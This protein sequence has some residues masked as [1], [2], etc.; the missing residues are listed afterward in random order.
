MEKK[1]PDLQIDLPHIEELYSYDVDYNATYEDDYEYVDDYSANSIVPNTVPKIDEVHPSTT[2]TFAH[3]VPKTE[4]DE[5]NK[6]VHPPTASTTSFQVPKTE[7]TEHKQENPATA[8][9]TSKLPTPV[10]TSKPVVLSTTEMPTTQISDDL[11]T[12]ND[13]FFEKSPPELIPVDLPANN[14]DKSFNNL[15][16]SFMDME[17][18]PI[19]YLEESYIDV[20]IE[21]YNEMEN[22]T[23]TE[24]KTEMENSESKRPSSQG[25]Q[26]YGTTTSSFFSSTT[27][28]NKKSDI[29]QNSSFPVKKIMPS[30]TPTQ[31]IFQ[32]ALH[33]FAYYIIYEIYW[34]YWYI[35]KQNKNS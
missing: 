5:H 29:G 12:D 22:K 9:T 19:L 14:F 26:S 20:P 8:A 28:Q 6:Q 7:E 30:L 4:E 25:R 16:N 23:I 3:Q 11:S 27:D 18:K 32:N 1:C 17:H 13:I 21:I 15:T 2:G 34:Y 35:E 33:N 10:K 24:N 31:S